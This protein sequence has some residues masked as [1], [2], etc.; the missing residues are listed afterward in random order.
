MFRPIRRIFST[1]LYPGTA[2]LLLSGALLMYA[3]GAWG[4]MRNRPPVESVYHHQYD[5]SQLGHSSREVAV[6]YG[7]ELFRNTSRYIGPE[8]DRP[9]AGNHLSCNNCH[10]RG[11]TQPYAAPL[12]G[13]AQR[14]PQFRGRENKVGTLAERIDG[15]MERSMN[16][17]ALPH[18]SK[19]MQALLAYLEWLSRYAP[20]DGVVEGQG[21]V[22]IQIPNRAIDTTH[23]KEI[24]NTHC[25]SCHGRD[26]QGSRATDGYGYQY[27][28]LW[29]PDSYNHGAG[30][31][32]VITAANFIKANMPYGTTHTTPILTDEEAFDVAGFINLQDR[33]QKA[34]AEADFPDLIKKPVSTPYGPYADD[35]PISQHRMGPFQPILEYYQQKYSVTKNQ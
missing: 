22:K 24:F 29:G 6:K 23:G 8:S 17:T 12:I 13:I 18:D 19:E 10:L 33:P 2:L 9:F 32:R 15:C 34:N 4:G 21:F 26:G 28:P 25:M 20:E 27:P 1:L 31:T 7:Y 16:G 3:S 11:G 35:F 30:M 14:F 5:P